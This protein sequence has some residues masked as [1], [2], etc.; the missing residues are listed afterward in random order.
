MLPWMTNTLTAPESSLSSAWYG[1]LPG[2]VRTKFGHGSPVD[3]LEYE[4][5]GKYVADQKQQRFQALFPY[6]TKAISG[7]GGGPGGPLPTISAGPIWN[8]EMVQQQVNASRANTDAAT[9]SR[10]REAAQSLSGRGFGSNSP[11]L[12]AL[13]GSFGR[14]GMAQNAESERNI[15][16]GAAEGN[17]AQLL[18]SQTARSDQ[19]LGSRKIQ[20]DQISALLSALAGFG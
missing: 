12:A 19:E 4:P 6:F 8:Q 16:F 5:L 11:L 18:K 2:L 10:G 3:G 13:Q 20:A 17:A 1:A 15:R 14:Q 9:A 7:T